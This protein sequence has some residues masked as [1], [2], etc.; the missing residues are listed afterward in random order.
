MSSPLQF[1]PTLPLSYRVHFSI[2]D[3]AGAHAHKARDD[4]FLRSLLQEIAL[5]RE[6]VDFVSGLGSLSKDQNMAQVLNRSQM[7]RG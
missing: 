3:Y 4:R 1:A 7:T 2:L 5:L 6:D